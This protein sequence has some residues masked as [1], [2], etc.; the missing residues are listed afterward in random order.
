MLSK[1]AVAALLCGATFGAVPSAPPPVPTSGPATPSAPAPT[2][3]QT[4][5]FTS[6][7]TTVLAGHVPGGNIS[8]QMRQGFTQQLL[9]QI[10]AAFAGE[11]KFR[12]L[13]FVSADTI[14][15]YLRYHYMAVFE[16]GSQGIVFILDSNGTIVGFFQDKS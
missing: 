3:K 14:Q 9:G 15:Q 7:F 13:Q 12:E 2:S 10:A 11:G 5:D 4:A 8:S 6:F 1:L 16:N